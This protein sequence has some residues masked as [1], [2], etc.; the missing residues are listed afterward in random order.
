[1]KTSGRAT[2]RA[3]LDAA[4]RIQRLASSKL[5]ALSL[6]A[7]ICTAAARNFIVAL[8]GIASAIQE[9]RAGTLSQHVFGGAAYDH[10]DDAPVPIGADE[11]EIVIKFGQIVDYLLLRIAAVNLIAGFDGVRA[12][13]GLGLLQYIVCH[14]LF[15]G[16][17]EH[18]QGKAQHSTEFSRRFHG[19]TRSLT[20]IVSKHRPL[21]S[22][23]LLRRDKDGARTLPRYAFCSCAQ[24][25]GGELFVDS[26]MA[27][28]HEIRNFGALADFIGN[29]AHVQESLMFDP[30]ITAS[31]GKIF[32]N[33]FA[34][35]FQDFTHL[36][37]KVEV[38]FES[39]R[40]GNIVKKSALD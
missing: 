21:D 31:L 22:F 3:P 17:G 37:G 2:T 11:Q 9:N 15:F 12:Q 34:S 16:D 14:L 27:N 40:A 26:P 33:N 24:K 4:A 23:E 7:N 6:E 19:R 8:S 18:G 36:R 20:A 32:Q 39:E 29:Q 1:M 13:I 38:R 25:A 28:N 35:F 5:A 30:P 10:F